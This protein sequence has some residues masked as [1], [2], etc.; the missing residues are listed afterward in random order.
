MQWIL[1]CVTFAHAADLK[2]QTAACYDRNSAADCAQLSEA[3]A[4]KT[5][6]ADRERA[7]LARLRAC[8]LGHT[9]AC[10]AVKTASPPVAAAKPEANQIM[11]L[12]RS[13]VDQQLGDLPSLLQAARL[14]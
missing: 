5:S 6:P 2:K 4:K 3:L 9:S 12:K 10:A 11:K 8:K 14:Q 7:K 1:I 13:D